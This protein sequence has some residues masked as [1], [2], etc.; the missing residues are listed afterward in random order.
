MGYVSTQY[1]SVGPSMGYISTQNTKVGPTLGSIPT[2]TYMKESQRQLAS[3]I[4]HSSG[5]I[6]VPTTHE[7]SEKTHLNHKDKINH[8]LDPMI[9]SLLLLNITKIKTKLTIK[10]MSD[11]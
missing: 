3:Y 10:E 8:P 6:L 1:T 5:P 7:Y 4:T 11:L 2:Q 9:S